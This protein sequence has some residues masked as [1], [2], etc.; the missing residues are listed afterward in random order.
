MEDERGRDVRVPL[1]SSLFCLFVVTGG[2]FL[3]L[4][5]FTPQFSQPWFPIAALILIGSPWLFWF[6][7]YIY[8][9][10]KVCFRG[11]RVEDRQISRRGNHGMQRATTMTNTATTSNA[12]LNSPNDAAVVVEEEE[13]RGYGHG[14]GGGGDS[15][16][17]SSRESCSSE[18]MGMKAD[19]QWTRGKMPEKFG[20]WIEK[21]YLLRQTQMVMMNEDDEATYNY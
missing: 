15:S 17:T 11:S 14:G 8:T 16:V 7:T 6:L 3:M 10:M 21:Y 20:K 9:C 18:G 4:Y 2:V 19:F 12:T 5:V 13:S 1:I